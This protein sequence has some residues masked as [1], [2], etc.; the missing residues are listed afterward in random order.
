MTEF[1]YLFSPLRVKDTMIKNRIISAPMGVPKA[2]IISS[3]DYG[4]ISVYDKSLGGAGVVTVGDNYYAAIANEKDYFSKYA[5]DVGKELISVTRQ[6][7]GLSML[8]IPF[9][10]ETNEDGTIQGPS[11][12]KHY[13]GGVMRELTREEMSEIKKT[14]AKKAKHA[15]DLGFD[16]VMLHFG[17][18]S[19]CSVFMSPVWNQRNDEYG[20]SLENRI[21]FPKEVLEAVR[22]EVGNK[23]PI[24]VRVSRHLKVPESFEE[25]DMMYFLKSVENSI[26]IVNV[27]CGMDCYG[28]TIDKYVANT[29]SHSTIFLPHMYN[30]GFAARVKKETNLLV[31]TVGGF[32]D[33]QKADEAIR[34]GKTDM[35]MMGRQLIADPFWP[36][37]A[38]N[39]QVKDIVP[40]L[41]CLNCYH[42]S[43]EHANTQCS[44]N[45]R[46]R[47]ENRVPLKL[48]KTSDPKHI[49]IIGG[50]PAGMKAALTAN[51][52]GHKVTLLEKEKR[53]GGNLKYAD[54]GD[55]KEDLRK[56]REYLIHEISKTDIDVRLGI[57]ATREYVEQLKP[58]GLIIAVGSETFTPK[59]KGVEYGKQALDVYPKLDDVSGKIVVIGGG[60]IGSE[61]AFE[62][63]EKDSNTVSVIEMQDALAKKSN[64][65]YRHGLYNAIRDAGNK[66]QVFLKSSVKEITKD[67]VVFEQNG[68]EKFVEADHV[69]LAVGMKERKELA[70]SFYGITPEVAMIGDCYKVAQV[71]EATNDAYF[72]AANM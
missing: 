44:V 10:G 20:G 28:G 72:V 66:L 25:D 22:K 61:L 21:R 60:A 47:R 70:F 5:K 63:S 42:I 34:D 26:D 50:G 43:T 7:G 54:Y 17:H 57:N 58:D 11:N 29:Y 67:G 13:T 8:E 14:I 48:E 4:G 40:C 41:R 12:G 31:C 30:L 33:P 49:V 55:F 37:K 46:F 15:K 45:P 39:G 53:L 38:Q 68:E 3:T 24:L 32:S 71:L 65:L 19:L 51:E 16:L 69:I 59:I 35:I 52:K 27:S 23:Y 62:L 36:K 9:H 56:Y 64:W 2:K 1:K 18:D 6:A